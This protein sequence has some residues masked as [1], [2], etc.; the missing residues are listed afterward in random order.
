MTTRC[1]TFETETVLS[2]QMITMELTVE[3]NPLRVVP[4]QKNV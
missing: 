3:Q 2:Q 1:S 4:H